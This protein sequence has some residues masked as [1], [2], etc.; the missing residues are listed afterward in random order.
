MTLLGKILTVLVL[1]MSILFMGFS[2]VVYATH[3]NWKKLVDNPSPAPGE[4]LG[5]KQRFEQQ[6]QT[7]ER[8]R[9]ELEKLNTLLASEQAA[10]RF[11]LAA[12]ETK[13]DQAEQQLRDRERAVADLQAT[14]LKNT[15]DLELLGKELAQLTTQIDSLKA[16]IVSTQQ[17]RDTQFDVVL[18]LSDELNQRMGEKIRLAERQTQLLAEMARMED[19][20]TK[21]GLTA[22]TDVANIPPAVDG[23]VTQVGDRDLIEISI[24][25]D[26]GL[27]RGHHLDVFRKNVYLGRIVII[28]TEP[29]KAV[30]EILKEYRKGFIKK[31]DRVA[32]KLS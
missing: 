2:I 31:G 17:D 16:D 18:R 26:D 10:R 19:V 20:L 24:G 5:Y 29:D 30:G 6:V 4:Q 11:A 32:T 27:R 13:R 28:D 22:E 8:L 9:A 15:A 25:S 14:L 3:T 12:A 7:A 21:H 1:I 23:Y